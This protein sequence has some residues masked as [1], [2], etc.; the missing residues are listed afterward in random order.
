MKLIKTYR[1]ERL[2]FYIFLLLIVTILGITILVSYQT[3]SAVIAQT[4]SRY[5]QR[6]LDELNNQI[7]TRLSMIEQISLSISRDPEILSFLEPDKEPYD[8]YRKTKRIEQML[9]NLTYSMSM[10]QAVSL[11]SKDPF[12]EEKVKYIQFRPIESMIKEQWF[13]LLQHSDFAWSGEHTIISV[14]GPVPVIS[15]ARKMNYRD[16]YSGVIVIH[17]K[18]EEIRTILSDRSGT[19]A[20]MMLNST[21][22]EI[23]SV[24]NVPNHMRFTEWLNSMQQKSGVI[25]NSA[26]GGEAEPLIVYSKPQNSSWAIV[27]ITPW[28]QITEGSKKLALNIGIVGVAAILLAVAL[29]LWL[30][31]LF[32]KPIKLL[33]DAMNSYTVGQAQ[34]ELPKDYKNEFGYLFAGYRRQKERIEELYRDLKIRYDQQ[35]KAELEALQANI[36]PHFLYNTLNQLSWMA[37]SAGQDNMS[38][39][40]ELMGRMF[41]ISLSNGESFITV[42]E[43]IMHIESYLEIQQLR[44]ENGLHYSIQVEDALNMLYV[45]KMTLQPFV[46]NSVIH[47]LYSRSSGCIDITF[48]SNND[49]LQIMICDDGVGLTPEAQKPKKHHIGG[50]YG[51]RNVKDRLNAYFGD[52]SGVI[53]S[54][55]EGGGTIVTIQMPKMGKRPNGG[56]QS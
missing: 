5:Q 53:V 52:K 39:I 41:R 18:A 14:K 24:G 17:I 36:N 42:Q 45:P 20:R 15:F 32:T 4:S 51:I 7:T 27:E 1:I 10:V 8:K 2:F 21:G 12:L 9:T 3:S 48:T 37:I 33:V 50:G 47:G 40:L 30:S 25:R 38:R 26:F 43:E 56:D 54:P 16:Q 6:L 22:E 44:L 29:T 28:D 23:L 55:R 49:A 13:E 35:R 46:E 19:A 34:P 31:K 11:Y